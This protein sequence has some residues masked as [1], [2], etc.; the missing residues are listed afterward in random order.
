MQ[1]EG[2]I[3]SAS[4]EAP[5]MEVATL[6]GD[7]HLVSTGPRATTLTIEVFGDITRFMEECYHNS[8]KVALV[9][10]EEPRLKSWFK[11]KFSDITM[12][13]VSSSPP[14]LV[15]TAVRSPG[16]VGN[17][18][19]TFDDEIVPPSHTADATSARWQTPEPEWKPEPV[20]FPDPLAD[21]PATTDSDW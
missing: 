21:V 15:S 19:C 20:S 13:G 6:S 5:T 1:I 14:P 11:G 8:G 12:G 2:K 3:L 4:V 18:N 9:V 7:R 16:Y 17:C 10:S